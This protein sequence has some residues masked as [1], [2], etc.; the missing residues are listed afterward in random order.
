MI[1][2]GGLAHSMGSFEANLRG[3]VLLVPLDASFFSFSF[4]FY[5]VQWWTGYVHNWRQVPV[6]FQLALFVRLQPSSNKWNLGQ[7]VQQAKGARR[8]E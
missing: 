6:R 4:S 8:K 1:Q 3:L 7:G 2:K 5:F